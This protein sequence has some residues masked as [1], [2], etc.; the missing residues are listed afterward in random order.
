MQSD[1]RVV[2]SLGSSSN[3][4]TQE[5]ERSKEGQ[6]FAEL[7]DRELELRHAGTELSIVQSEG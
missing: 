3:E 5:I 2:D 1:P 6:L 7:G 4:A